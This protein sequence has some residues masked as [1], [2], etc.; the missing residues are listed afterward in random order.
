MHACT[1]TIKKKESSLILYAVFWGG[2][3]SLSFMYRAGFRLHRG[4][5]EDIESKCHYKTEAQRTPRNLLAFFV[6]FLFFLY[7]TILNVFF[8]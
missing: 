6:F 8:N 3:L 7:L 5:L 4:A 2:S 1:N